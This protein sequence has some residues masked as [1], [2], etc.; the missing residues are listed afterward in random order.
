MSQSP[1]CA[2]VVDDDA[3]VLASIRF[4]LEAEGLNVLTF[5]SAKAVLA[6]D[7]PEQGCLILDQLM[8]GATGLELLSQLRQRGVELPALL[9]TSSATPAVRRAAQAAETPVLEK[10]VFGETLVRTF[11]DRAS[12]GR[13]PT[14]RPRRPVRGIRENQQPPA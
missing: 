12:T 2:V 4:V 6:A 5:E 3:A 14:A 8:P 9:L 7:L 1:Y 10:P 11:L 13:R